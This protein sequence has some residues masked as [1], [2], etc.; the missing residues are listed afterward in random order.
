[1]N[2]VLKLDGDVPP[3]FRIAECWRAEGSKVELW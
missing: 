2:Y 1:M 3:L